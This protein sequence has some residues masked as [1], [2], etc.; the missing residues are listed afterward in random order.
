MM[1]YRLQQQ[2][3]FTWWYKSHHFAAKTY[4][5]DKYKEGK[6]TS[7]HPPHNIMFV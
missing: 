2:L 6:K 3:V 7:I 4:H 5:T 1:R